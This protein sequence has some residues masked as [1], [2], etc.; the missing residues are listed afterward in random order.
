MSKYIT[1]TLT[2]AANKH[3]ASSMGGPTTSPI[4]I[5]VTD[6][7]D[8]TEITHKVLDVTTSNAVLINNAD[9]A[10]A[11]T[12]G[13]EGAFVFLKNLTT[14][15][16]IYIGHGADAAL[17]DGGGGEATRL[18]TLKPK[19]FAWFPYDLENDLIY[20]ADSAVAGGLEAIIFVRTG[21]A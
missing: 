2:V 3:D 15:A 10:V 13:T 16:D 5:A 18:M 1:P 19:E 11:I 8:V 21:T 12:A 17:E 9:Y 6:D 14:T 4:N 7:L 20:D